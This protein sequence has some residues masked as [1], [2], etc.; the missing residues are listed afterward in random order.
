MRPWKDLPPERPET[1]GSLVIDERI[2]PIV[3]IR[4]FD[5]RTFYVARLWGPQEAHEE[6]FTDVRIIGEDGTAIGEYRQLIPR[7]T[8]IHPG[9]SVTLVIPMHITELI[10][11]P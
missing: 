10:P 3:D 5:R 6:A 4:L 1:L 7:W 9:F 8:Y 2:F 11:T